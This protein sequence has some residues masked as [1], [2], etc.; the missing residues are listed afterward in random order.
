MAVS[1][2]VSTAALLL[3]RDH[4]KPL[5]HLE[6][7]Q[8]YER[9]NSYYCCKLHRAYT[10]R[11]NCVCVC[12]CVQGG[13]YMCPHV[14][15][16]QTLTG[17]PVMLGGAKEQECCWPCCYG[18]LRSSALVS[19]CICKCICTLVYVCVCVCLPMAMCVRQDNQERKNKRRTRKRKKKVL[20]R[21]ILLLE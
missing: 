6:N 10:V 17:L 7:Q 16:L 19:L 15:A 11:S 5:D 13:G 21:R 1:V 18:N 2:H 12:V 4:L 8:K 3:Y 20:T 9:W 14:S